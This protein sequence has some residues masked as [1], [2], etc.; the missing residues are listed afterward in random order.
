MV[1]TVKRLFGKPVF[2]R[3]SEEVLGKVSDLIFDT[4][5]DVVV[6]LLMT[7]NSIIPFTRAVLLKDILQVGKSGVIIN[8]AAKIK[9]IDLEELPG[10]A[11]T[12][13]E[14]FHGQK[15]KRGRTF[16]REKIRDAVFDFEAS[17]L[18]D[19][20]LSDSRLQALFGKGKRVS[21]RDVTENNGEISIQ[22]KG[23]NHDE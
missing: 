13:F 3:D 9:T 16:S 2:E 7:T 17:E 8:S 10:H 6:A 14:H 18:T 4:K 23:G 21:A 22:I 15:V 12:Y 11:V 19:F 5:T 20:I 1:E